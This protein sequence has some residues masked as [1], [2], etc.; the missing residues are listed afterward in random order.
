[1]IPE[2]DKA[3][4]IRLHKLGYSQLEI[5]K[6]TGHHNTTVHGVLISEGAINSSH[7]EKMNTYRNFTDGI[8]QLRMSTK[9]GDKVNVRTF[10]STDGYSRASIKVTRPAT[11]VQ[12]T[13]PKFCMVKLD[14]GVLDTVS[15][16][17]LYLAN[18]GLLD[19][20]DNY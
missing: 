19:E 1:M 5:G 7:V 8:R 10:K 3:E 17:D 16:Q 9:V 6:M 4:M 15:W 14:T 20:D 13:H 11:V 18:R 2:K 12:V